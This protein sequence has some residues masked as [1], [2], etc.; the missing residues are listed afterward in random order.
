LQNAWKARSTLS[1]KKE[2]PTL[3]LAVQQINNKL[4]SGISRSLAAEL[5]NWF[6]DQIQEDPEEKSQAQYCAALA[7]YAPRK[8]AACFPL[9]F[10]AFPY[11]KWRSFVGAYLYCLARKL[12]QVRAGEGLYPEVSRACSSAF[13][14]IRTITSG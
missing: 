4:R 7:A 8:H 2:N 1:S 12:D 13:L 10:A 3:A 14:L 9:A 11:V 5:P 6:C